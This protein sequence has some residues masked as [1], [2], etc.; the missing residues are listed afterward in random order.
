M[1]RHNRGHAIFLSRQ[2]RIILHSKLYSVWPSKCPDHSKPL[3]HLPINI[4]SAT[5]TFRG[6]VHI[7]VATHNVESTLW[8]GGWVFTSTP[9]RYLTYL[10]AIWLFTS[11]Q[12]EV[13]PVLYYFELIEF[14]T[15]MEVLKWHLSCQIRVNLCSRIATFFC[16]K[17]SN[18][19]KASTIVNNF[20][21]KPRHFNAFLK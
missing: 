5:N 19:I 7:H 11:E 18:F 16:D 9:R 13:L 1:S 12:T 10:V 21:L 4:W 17:T 2:P 15:K 6:H 14:K 8:V 20:E 3:K